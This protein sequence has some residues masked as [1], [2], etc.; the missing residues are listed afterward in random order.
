MIHFPPAVVGLP[1]PVAT[2]QIAHKLERRKKIP[3]DAEE[4]YKETEKSIFR[5]KEKY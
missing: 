2:K 4:K 3:E 5:R 1:L